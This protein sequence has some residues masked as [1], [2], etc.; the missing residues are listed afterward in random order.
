[1]RVQ[2][3][4]YISK[5]ESEKRCL[6]WWIR[7]THMDSFTD[8]P[9]YHLPYRC[10]EP[11]IQGDVVCAK[12]FI[13]RAKPREKK[14]FSPAKWWGLVTEPIQDIGEQINHLAF[15][16]WFYEKAK[17]YSLSEES[18]KKAKRL[19]EDATGSTAN[20][21][22]PVSS[23]NDTPKNEMV[24]MN[25]SEKKKPGRKKKDAV[26]ADAVV[27]E[28]KVD[29]KKKRAPKL[30]SSKEKKVEE[31]EAVKPKAV[32]ADEPVIEAVDVEYVH[33]KAFQ[34]EGTLYYL[35]SKKSK[36]YDRQKDGS[37]KGV[38][39]GRWDSVAEKIVTTLPDSDAEN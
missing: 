30:V 18:M 27:K 23:V 37:C 33:V 13:K 24:N 11:R 2:Y 32:I 10:L 8:G 35:E 31:V 36:L 39:K 4:N 5:M 22:P 25:A 6:A 20:V 34:H 16:P 7:D 38:Y 28:E 12:C 26:V 9:K 1:M 19:L 3:M 17:Q 21:V 15:S 14:G 29:I